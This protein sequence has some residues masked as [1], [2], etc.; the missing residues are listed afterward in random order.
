MVSD[1][2]RPFDVFAEQVHTTRYVILNVAYTAEK[3]LSWLIM[4]D[5]HIICIHDIVTKLTF[6]KLSRE[7]SLQ[8]SFNWL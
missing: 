5:M 7:T 4:K 8:Y 2:Q 6:V 3:L 1:G